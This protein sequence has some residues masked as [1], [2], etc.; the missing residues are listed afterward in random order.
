M[1]DIGEIYREYFAEYLKG[2]EDPYAGNP[3]S[4]P[5]RKTAVARAQKKAEL[6]KEEYREAVLAAAVGVVVVGPDNRVR[7]F[8]DV[9]EDEGSS[10]VISVDSV[11]DPFVESLRGA[12]KKRITI[13]EVVALR[14]MIIDAAEEAGI[15]YRELPDITVTSEG[16]D[17]VSL[18]EAVNR[19]VSSQVGNILVEKFIEEKTFLEALTIGYSYPILP[20]TV[21]GLDEPIETLFGKPV[22]VI[23]LSKSMPTQETLINTYRAI[24]SRYGVEEPQ[25]TETE[26]KKEPPKVEAKTEDKPRRGPGRPKGSK[27][28]KKEEK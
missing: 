5:A 6:L 21:W 19:Y 2:L 28:K 22:E 24:Q 10:L 3:T 14:E 23:D 27:N 25:V 17:G 15:P 20:V 9:V 16:F 18:E 26:E 7:Q 11:Y 13:N 12:G 8:L 1:R 4:F